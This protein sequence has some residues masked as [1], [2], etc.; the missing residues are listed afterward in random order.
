[1]NTIETL[2]Y[3]TWCYRLAVAVVIRNEDD[4]KVPVCKPCGRDALANGP[5][6]EARK[7]S[8]GL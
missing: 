3:C 2:P 8:D 7:D 5:F 6:H 1:M 4:K